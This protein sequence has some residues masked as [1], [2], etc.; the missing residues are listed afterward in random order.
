MIVVTFL[1]ESLEIEQLLS[2]LHFGSCLSPVKKDRLILYLEKLPA[3]RVTQEIY[4]LAPS[5]VE[6]K[7]NSKHRTFILATTYSVLAPMGQ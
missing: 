2:L 4:N 3:N 7:S 6:T 5:R 1:V